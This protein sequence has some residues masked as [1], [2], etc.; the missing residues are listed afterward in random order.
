M[1]VEAAGLAS[2]RRTETHLL[3]MEQSLRKFERNASAGAP[4]GG[5]DKEFH[6]T[7]AAATANERFVKFLGEH[8]QRLIPPVSYGA[9]MVTGE[10]RKRFLLEGTLVEHLRIFEAISAKDTAASR[11]AM[12]THLQNTPGSFR[13]WVALKET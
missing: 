5:E 4:T 8:A 1:E 6:Q 13:N 12:R 3:W 9:A 10:A 7:I 2:Q 11:E